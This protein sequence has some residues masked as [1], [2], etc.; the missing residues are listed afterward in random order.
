[1]NQLF[2]FKI[3]E[4]LWTISFPVMQLCPFRLAVYHSSWNTSHVYSSVI[5]MS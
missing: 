2:L 4:R 3:S 1:M 5:I